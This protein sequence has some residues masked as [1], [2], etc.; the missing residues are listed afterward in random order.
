MEWKINSLHEKLQSLEGIV[1]RLIPVLNILQPAVFQL[2]QP[3][4]DVFN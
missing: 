4:C 3:K 1:V 2:A